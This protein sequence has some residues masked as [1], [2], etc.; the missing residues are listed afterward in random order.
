MV[1]I[2][3]GWSQ[4]LGLFTGQSSEI[5]CYHT[6]TSNLNSIGFLLNLINITHVC[7]FAQS[8]IL[9]VTDITDHY[10]YIMQQIFL[11]E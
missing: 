11:T 10:L 4:L 2:T 3:E 9:N 5:H 7:S 1:F 6:D 8:P